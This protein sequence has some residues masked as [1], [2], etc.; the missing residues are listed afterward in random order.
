MPVIN[1]DKV[2]F[3]G[4]LAGLFSCFL[5]DLVIYRPNRLSAGD[6]LSLLDTG[7]TL[8][9]AVLLIC[10]GL[11]VLASLFKDKRLSYLLLVLSSSILGLSFDVAGR[12]AHHISRTGNLFAR[13]SLG[14]GAWLTL[15]AVLTVIIHCYQTAGSDRRLKV[16]CV[17]IPAGLIITL[18]TNGN[19]E[20]L[21]LMKEYAN[22]QDRF[23]NELLVHLQLAL[24]SSGLSA[25]VGIPLGITLT[26]RPLLSQQSFFILNIIQTIPSIALFALL[27]SPLAFLSRNVEL[28]RMLGIQGIGW[29]PA[30]IALFLYSLLP[31]VR[32]T[33]TGLLNIDPSIVES[34]FGM[35]MTKGQVLRQ[36]KLPLA[37]VVILN[38][39]RIAAVQSIGN[40]AVAALIG[41]GGFGIFIFQ[42]L[43]QAATDLILLGAIPTI[44]MA[45]V[46]DL[47]FQWLSSLIEPGSK[48]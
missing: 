37:G 24:G 8:P 44:V 22:R 46:A 13:V 20:Q 45:V 30:L 17:I 34:A 5:L 4:A 41:A 39:F 31:I 21:S 18:L 29:A 7:F 10:W 14:A 32:N 47:V 48:K 2:P 11:L 19:L 42:G 3:T 27:I 23:Y 43:G 16:L 1:I 35:G 40:T 25:L 12:Y 9:A 26:R 33:Y 6:G 38:G 28:V 15:V 36:V